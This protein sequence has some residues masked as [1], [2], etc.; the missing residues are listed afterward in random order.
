M[1]K[2]ALI[3]IILLANQVFGQADTLRIATYNLLQFQHENALERG[4]FMRTVINA[5]DPDVIVCQEVGSS[6]YA[7]YFREEIL[8]PN[9]YSLAEFVDGPDSDN[10]MC[11]KTEKFECIDVIPVGTPLR[12]IGVYVLRYIDEDEVPLL[13]V[14]SAHFQGS[15]GG[16]NEQA[17]LAEANE[18]LDFMN[19][20]DHT[21][22]NV[23]LCG[24]LNVYASEE[25]AYQALLANDLF[26]DPIDTPGDWHDNADFANIHTQ[27]PRSV[28]FGGGAHGGMDDRFD[29]LLATQ[30]FAN[31]E[32]WSILEG[33]Y[34]AFG[35]DGR[36]LNQSIIEDGNDIVSEEIANALHEASDHIPV[37]MDVICQIPEVEFSYAIPLRASWNLISSPVPPPETDMAVV[38]EEIVER[39]NL[40]IV[41]DGSGRF[42][43]PEHNFNNI[44]D[45]DVLYGYQ[46]KVGEADVL[47]II[48][49]NPIDPR[50]EIPLR[51]GWSLVAYFPEEEV[52]APDALVNIGNVLLMVKDGLGR[53]YIPEHGFSNMGLL[54]R[55]MG[56]QI[57]TMDAAELVWNVPED[58]QINGFVNN[59][60]PL[61]QPEYFKTS[62][63]TG[64]NMSLLISIPAEGRTEIG[65]FT[66]SGSCVGASVFSG[67]DIFGIAVW[68][69]D[70]TTEVIDGATEGELLSF[71][72]FDGAT[73]YQFNSSEIVGEVF[74]RTNGFEYLRIENHEVPTDL[75]LFEPYPNPFNNTVNISFFNPEFNIAD[76]SICDLHG[77]EVRKLDLENLS[78]G[79]NSLTIEASDFPNG[80]YLVRFNVNGGS[81][82]RK[83]VLL[84]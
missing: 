63:P 52:S 14:C 76:L 47:H 31:D 27:S 35:N 13:Y 59:S 65:V 84:K 73:E 33:S 8:D 83:I 36:H 20:Q 24:D 58:E 30:Q 77:R 75:R 43:T 12:N 6:F 23:L 21:E 62:S 1:R 64:Y 80:I 2:T 74:Y 40:E 22:D 48:N 69:D 11:F 26:Y 72:L 57:K 50:T 3:L 34:T 82:S 7:D 61:S 10:L 78:V 16:R 70:P 42:Y 39:N 29:H 55:G 46:A 25:P 37:F 32:G 49:N 44:T 5:I 15:S 79:Y 71:K 18:F 28:Q 38:W 56:Y 53:F 4:E 54:H 66:E 17:R 67:S 51:S 45:W 68:G 81:I 41:K 19:E 9:V 60:N